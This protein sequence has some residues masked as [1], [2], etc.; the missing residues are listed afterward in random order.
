[1]TEISKLTADDVAELEAKR[2]WVRDHYDE[3][4]RHKYG[5]LEGKLTLLGTILANDWIRPDETLKLQC[6]GATFGDA[7]VQQL[8][9][10]WA[11]VD[12]EYGRSLCVVMPDAPVRAFPMTMISKRVEDGETIDIPELFD[13]VCRTIEK[14]CEDCR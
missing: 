7:L 2:S 4:S 10:E 1:M 8:G 3:S 13:G 6:L 9:M 11:V 5:N 12:D 14:A